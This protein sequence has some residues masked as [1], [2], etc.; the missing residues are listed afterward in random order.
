MTEPHDVLV[1]IRTIHAR[2]ILAG[3]KTVELRRRFPTIEAGTRLWIYETLPTG[4]IVGFAT[5]MN[6]H[7]ATPEVLWERYGSSFG[8]AA[9]EFHSYL[10]GCMEAV[11]IS[12]SNVRRIALIPVATL[13]SIRERF[14]PPQVMIRLTSAEGIALREI[15]GSGVPIRPS[16]HAPRPQLPTVGIAI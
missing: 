2:R 14:H 6:L 10:D 1:S 15:A 8:L 12:L 13:R 4:A 9:V 11:A 5:A 3:T 16:E 7:R